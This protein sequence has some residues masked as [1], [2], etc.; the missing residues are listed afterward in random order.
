MVF[1]FLVPRAASCVFVSFCPTIRE[2]RKKEPRV[3][4]IVI[5]FSLSEALHSV[6]DKNVLLLL[7]PTHCCTFGERNGTTA[8]VSSKEPAAK[9]VDSSSPIPLKRSR[10]CDVLSWC[11]AT[12][13]HLEALDLAKR[14]LI[15]PITFTIILFKLS[16]RQTV[17]HTHTQI[18]SGIG[19]GTVAATAWPLTTKERLLAGRQQ[20]SFVAWPAGCRFVFGVRWR[21]KQIFWHFERQSRQRW[22][23][24]SRKFVNMNRLNNDRLM[25]V[26][27]YGSKMH[28]GTF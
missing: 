5:N 9:G 27:D 18:G 16:A 26:S 22:A 3:R 14:L 6:R 1:T 4:E 17:S 13:A 23:Y 25:M 20:T 8:A 15:K 21:E 11:P 24:D 19:H 2:Y 12:T 10:S 7:R 28:S